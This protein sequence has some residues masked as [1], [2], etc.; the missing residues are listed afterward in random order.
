VWVDRNADR[1]FV[2]F[3][4]DVRCDGNAEAVDVDT[5]ATAMPDQELMDVNSEGYLDTS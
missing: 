3:V 5:T 1:Y 2:T 4:R